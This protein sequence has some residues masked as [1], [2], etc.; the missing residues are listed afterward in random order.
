MDDQELDP[1]QVKEALID[2]VVDDY[3]I[4]KALGAGAFGAAFEAEHIKN[5][6]KA[7]IKVALGSNRNL[8]FEA[9]TM[10]RLVDYQRKHRTRHLCRI[11]ENGELNLVTDKVTL[12]NAYITME[13]APGNMVGHIAQFYGYDFLITGCDLAL[14]TL[15]GLYNLHSLGIIHRDFKAENVG[16]RNDRTP[17]IL[18]FGLARIVSDRQGNLRNARSKVA[19]RGTSE[20]ASWKSEMGFEQAWLI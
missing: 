3:K 2:F 6:T 10:Q 17:V 12:K 16:M 11:Y 18:D 19:P 7:C 13:F 14:K 4:V 1:T 9:A 15:N 8:R 5:K 20:W